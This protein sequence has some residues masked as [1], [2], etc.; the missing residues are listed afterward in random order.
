M[1]L[2]AEDGCNHPRRTGCNRPLSS[3]GRESVQASAVVSRRSPIGSRRTT[4]E[5][6]TTRAHARAL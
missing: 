4:P 2:A 6:Y 3:R 5:K 1:V